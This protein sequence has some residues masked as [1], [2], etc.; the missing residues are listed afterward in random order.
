[1]PVDP[2]ALIMSR[3]DVRLSRN[4]RAVLDAISAQPSPQTLDELCGRCPIP[5]E[6][7]FASVRRLEDYRYIQR[8]AIR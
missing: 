6:Y 7:V 5:G 3:A 1:M 8:G 4:D 2:F